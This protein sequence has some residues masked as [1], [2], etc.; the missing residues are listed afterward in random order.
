VAGLIALLAVAVGGAF[1]A[2]RARPDLLGGASPGAEQAAH[3]P[4]SASAAFGAATPRTEPKVGSVAAPIDLDALP[5]EPS[6]PGSPSVAA[7]H[8]AH[9]SG[10]A[11]QRRALPGPTIA[12]GTAA[13]HKHAGDDELDV[14]Y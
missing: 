3:G 5:V 12:K 4:Q 6:A 2:L 10:A 8:A 7:S 1:I 9:P 13:P 14:G 11:P